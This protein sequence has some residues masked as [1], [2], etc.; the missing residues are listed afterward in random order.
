MC[1]RSG[2]TRSSPRATVR[3]PATAPDAALA[4]ANRWFDRLRETGSP[5]RDLQKQV[6]KHG[7]SAV[8][9]TTGAVC[10]SV[11]SEDSMASSTMLTAS[12]ACSPPRVLRVL[13][14][15]HRARAAPRARAG[16]RGRSGSGAVVAAGERA[17]DGLRPAARRHRGRPCPDSRPWT[18]RWSRPQPLRPV[19]PGPIASTGTSRDPRCLTDSGGMWLLLSTGAATAAVAHLSSAR[20][21]IHGGVHWLAALAG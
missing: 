12:G 13:P 11:G 9:R 2:V 21:V 7:R 14:D 17:T 5:G 10:V 20:P 8:L 18:P 1:D 6:E 15:L 19:P 4:S 16:H 3:S